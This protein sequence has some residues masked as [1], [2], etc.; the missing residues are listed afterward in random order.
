MGL[1][2]KYI[3]QTRK[4][5]GILGTMMIK[6]MNIGHAKLADWGLAHMK[7]ARPADVIDLGCGGGRNVRALMEK[8]PY[9]HVTGLDYSPLSVEQ[10]EKY[11]RKALSQGRCAFTE[12]D[13]SSLDLEPESFDLATAFETVYF[14]PGLEKCFGEVCKILRP[15]GWFMIVN[16]S[17]GTDE[18]SLKYEEKIDGMK[19]HTAE[20]LEEALRAA[21]F[22]KVRCDHHEEK[23]WIVVV[24]KK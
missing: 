11:N 5:E 16:E 9:A 22:S 24:A 8:Y 12:G 19:C 7:S 21:G 23:P 10:A 1:I 18:T 14:W 17:D 20:T 13:V 3:N 2:N 15:G 4:P 6:G